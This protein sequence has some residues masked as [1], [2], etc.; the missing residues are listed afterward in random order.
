MKC[1]LFLLNGTVFRYSPHSKT[2]RFAFK[3]MAMRNHFI[4]FCLGINQKILF[5]KIPIKIRP[6]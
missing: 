4:V 3:L 6:I 5:I 2:I 1:L